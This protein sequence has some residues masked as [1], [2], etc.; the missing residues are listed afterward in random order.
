M[1]ILESGISLFIPLSEKKVN[2]PKY[3][4]WKVFII[5]STQNSPVWG[6]TVIRNFLAILKEHVITVTDEAVLLPQSNS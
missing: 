6:V 2:K 1:H 5:I 3:Y 4:T